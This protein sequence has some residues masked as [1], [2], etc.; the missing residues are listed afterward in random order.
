MTEEQ[1][2][3]P[4]KSK[5][6]TLYLAVGF[7]GVVCFGLG[8]I[9]ASNP[10]W[11]HSPTNASSIINLTSLSYKEG[12]AQ[13]YARR[14]TDEVINYTW[15]L[16]FGN[17]TIL[18]DYPEGVEE[19]FAVPRDYVHTRC[20]NGS[21]YCTERVCIVAKAM[22]LPDLKEPYLCTS[23]HFQDLE[24]MFRASNLTEEDIQKNLDAVKTECRMQE[25]E[26]QGAV[27]AIDVNAT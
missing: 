3:K 22:R 9:I 16:R 11:F 6:L 12:Y 18:I 25:I 24:N 26:R 2:F 10:P 15:Y 13:G 17:D 20:I 8:F 14:M 27:G 1:A 7:F 21:W 5:F 4:E 19:P 23:K